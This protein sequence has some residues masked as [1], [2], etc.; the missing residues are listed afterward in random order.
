MTVI[1]LKKIVIAGPSPIATFSH[2]C[3]IQL[4]STDTAVYVRIARLDLASGAEMFHV[5]LLHAPLGQYF[6]EK[7]QNIFEFLQVSDKKRIQ[8]RGRSQWILYCALL[9]ISS[10]NIQ[11]DLFFFNHYKAR[12]LKIT[13][14]MGEHCSFQC[15]II[16]IM[17]VITA[18]CN[19]V[20]LNSA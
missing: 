10:L 13:I 2:W 9:I 14:V 1:I 18:C 5:L 19:T 3:I 6:C 20:A 16:C 7:N 12:L 4:T 11:N 17:F 15:R 8:I